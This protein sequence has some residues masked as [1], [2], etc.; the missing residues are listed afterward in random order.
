M[1][2]NEQIRA[3]FATT[4]LAAKQRLVEVQQ[5]REQFYRE[6]AGIAQK[7]T[8]DVKSTKAYDFKE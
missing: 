3:T 2:V 1:Y 8:T 4:I 7:Y 5:R 6:A